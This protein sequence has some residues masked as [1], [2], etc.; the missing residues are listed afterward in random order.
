MTLQTFT[1]S[2]GPH[3]EGLRLP[4][5]MPL[6]DW[7]DETRSIKPAIALTA[8]A[9]LLL[10]ATGVA[11]KLGGF[12]SLRQLVQCWPIR[13]PPWNGERP[14]M[15]VLEIRAALRRAGTY[16]ISETWCLQ[17]SAALA[18]L[19][20][21]HGLRAHVVIGVQKL[22]FHAHAWAEVDGA[23]IN[24]PATFKTQLTVIERW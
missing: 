11:L 21:M 23:V 3:G 16:Y 18:C 20:R 13:R 10:V 4:D 7:C 1:K 15:L 24:G 2:T 14:A 12:G 8:V 17:K 5:R 19:L 6:H 9:W 22:P